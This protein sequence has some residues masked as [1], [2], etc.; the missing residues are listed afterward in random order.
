MFHQKLDDAKSHIKDS[1][2]EAARSVL[3]EHEN[4]VRKVT[5]EIRVLNENINWY[6]T[7]LSNAKRFCDMGHEQNAIKSIEEARKKLALIEK[8][9]KDLIVE[10]KNFLS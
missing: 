3:E 4:D 1:R 8:Q 10:E 7:H 9:T 5:E 2:L 6:L